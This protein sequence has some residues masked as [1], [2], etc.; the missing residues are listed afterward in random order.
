M[1][2]M[3]LLKK[4][5]FHGIIALACLQMVPEQWLANL[6]LCCL[7]LKDRKKKFGFCSACA[8]WLSTNVYF[9]TSGKQQDDFRHVQQSSE[10]DEHKILCPCFIRWLA[11]L[12]TANCLLEQW[13]AL[14]NYC[15]SLNDSKECSLDSV[16]H[17]MEILQTE[18]SKLYFYFLPAVLP[19]FEKFNLLF[20]QQQY[21]HKLHSE[22]CLILRQLIASFVQFGIIQKN[23]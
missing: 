15:D 16:K 22:A 21:I 19:R 13:S 12:H 6:I 1:L 3:H 20:Q 18:P 5:T 11:I 14:T 10:A 7:E 17:I 2:S 4:T 23:I 9:K 8:M